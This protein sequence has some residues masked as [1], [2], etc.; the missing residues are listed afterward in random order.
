CAATCLE[1]PAD[2]RAA[3][4]AVL[5]ADLA[6]TYFGWAPAR[7]DMAAYLRDI[8]AYPTGPGAFN[9]GWRTDR[10]LALAQD[11]YA[12]RSFERM[13]ELGDALV[14][15]GCDRWDIIGHCQL[16]SIHVR[17]CWLDLILGKA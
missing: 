17:G 3:F 11:M 2:E 16:S 13:S 12:R 8:F 7:E 4:L 9:D 10:V 14:A 6:D 1:F 15:T 5:I